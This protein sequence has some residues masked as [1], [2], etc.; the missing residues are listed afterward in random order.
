VA[1][2]VAKDGTF[3]TRDCI[4]LYNM[5][6]S[7]CIFTPCGIFSCKIWYV[8]LQEIEYFFITCGAVCVYLQQVV[9]LVAAD[10]TFCYKRLYISL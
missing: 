6:C 10:G 1:Y 9:Y 7:L 4:F 3:V 5:W 8:L 2:L